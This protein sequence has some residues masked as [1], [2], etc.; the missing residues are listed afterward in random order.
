VTRGSLA[1]RIGVV[2]F[3]VI[4]LA[5]L[6]GVLWKNKAEPNTVAIGP[7]Q[8]QQDAS[9]QS[10]DVSADQT[11]L[12]RPGSDLPGLQQSDPDQPVNGSPRPVS[13]RL[14]GITKK[15]ALPG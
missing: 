14:P 2:V 11:G 12:P 6:A 9:S 13:D 4:A 7:G 15:V 5:A 10:G 3:C 8:T 1:Y